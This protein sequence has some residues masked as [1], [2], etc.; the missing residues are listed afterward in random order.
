MT[1][2]VDA[3]NVEKS[4]AECEVATEQ[5]KAANLLLLNKKDLL[6]EVQL[7]AVRSKLRQINPT[8]PILTTQQ[9]DIKQCRIYISLLCG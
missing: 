1:T 4:L 2:I 5:I 7:Q 8:A 3:R 6:D 9:G